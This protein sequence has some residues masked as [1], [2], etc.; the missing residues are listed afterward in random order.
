MRRLCGREKAAS[1]YLSSSSLLL[2]GGRDKMQLIL[3]LCCDLRANRVQGS[4]AKELFLGC[5]KRPPP[6]ARGGQDAGITQPRDHSLAD[7]CSGGVGCVGAED[8]DRPQKCLLP[9]D[10][11]CTFYGAINRRNFVAI[12][13]KGRDDST[14]AP[15]CMRR[16]QRKG[17]IIV[18]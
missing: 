16:G 8:R 9:R 7:P 13:I 14:P 2:R 5:G 15:Q 6:V 4:A 1:C 3:M 12:K 18:G 10:D 11:T 17:T